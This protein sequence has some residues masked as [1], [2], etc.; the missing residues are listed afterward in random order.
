MKKYRCCYNVH[1]YSDR[2]DNPQWRT[3]TVVAANVEE[4]YSAMY[5]WRD[6]IGE[7]GYETRAGKRMYV[8]MV[9]QPQAEE[10]AEAPVPVGA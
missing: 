6:G 10:T 4:A 9:H 5:T 3:R 2:S 1:R 7:R 8:G